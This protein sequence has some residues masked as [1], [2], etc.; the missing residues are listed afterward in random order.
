MAD[1]LNVPLATETTLDQA[2]YFLK[3]LALGLHYSALAY[4]SGLALLTFS[5]RVHNAYCGHDERLRQVRS[6]GDAPPMDRSRVVRGQNLSLSEAA[7]CSPCPSLAPP[8]E[9]KKAEVRLAEE[10]R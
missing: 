9:V 10:K 3:E 6:T 4:V 5:R 1:A 8:A 2:D 7:F